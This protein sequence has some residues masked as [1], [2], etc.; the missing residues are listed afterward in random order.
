MTPADI[1]NA[2]R[3]RANGL[4]T[5]FHGPELL[6]AFDL[7]AQLAIS[8]LRMIDARRE[9]GM[10]IQPSYNEDELRRALD[11]VPQTFPPGPPMRPV[12]ITGS[13]RCNRHRRYECPECP[14]YCTSPV[15][16]AAIELEK[17]AED[18]ELVRGSHSDAALAR[19]KLWRTA[20]RYAAA[21]LEAHPSSLDYLTARD[22]AC[23][24]RTKGTEP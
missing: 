20:L 13:I 1:N 7:L 21:E 18:L 3:A 12:E 2:L 6:Q 23:H 9:L 22:A 17:A 15:N 24:L 16:A 19:Q 10:R 5:G 11:G 4:D 14:A 8:M